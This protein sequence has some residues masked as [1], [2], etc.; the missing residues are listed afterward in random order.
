MEEKRYYTPPK[1]WGEVFIFKGQFSRPHVAHCLIN[2]DFKAEPNVCTQWKPSVLEILIYFWWHFP[3]KQGIC[4]ICSTR[5][6]VSPLS[7]KVRTFQL[8]RIYMLDYIL[9]KTILAA[10]YLHLIILISEQLRGEGPLLRRQCRGSQTLQGNQQSLALFVYEFNLTSLLT[11]Y[12]NPMSVHLCELHGFIIFRKVLMFQAGHQN[13]LC[14][15]YQ[16]KVR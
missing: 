2:L 11:I 8:N 10:G 15:Y 12:A 4:L 14:A 3:G 16:K 1:I 5:C 6:H 9:P 13:R 7:D